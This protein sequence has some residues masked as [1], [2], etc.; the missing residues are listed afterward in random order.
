MQTVL[1]KCGITNGMIRKLKHEGLS[2]SKQVRPYKNAMKSPSEGWFYYVA[3][4]FT[5]PFTKK[6]RNYYIKNPEKFCKDLLKNTEFFRNTAGILYNAFRN[7]KKL[8]NEEALAANI[9]LIRLFHASIETLYLKYDRHF[10]YH[11]YKQ[12]P[13]GFHWFRLK[14]LCLSAAKNAT[15][16]NPKTWAEEKILQLFSGYGIVKKSQKT[17]RIA[18]QAYAE[19]KKNL[20][21]KQTDE[22]DKLVRIFRLFSITQEKESKISGGNIPDRDI[23]AIDTVCIYFESMVN[24]VNKNPEFIKKKYRNKFKEIAQEEN[25]LFRPK[26]LMHEGGNFFIPSVKKLYSEELKR[27]F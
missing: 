10:E 19:I 3:D 20:K 22:L 25:P 16:P 15:I 8:N 24:I 4:R 13:V 17:K 18:Q 5:P 9:A 11:D 6:E 7:L 21:G 12:S 26:K 2:V 23:G 14:E 1:E 27:W